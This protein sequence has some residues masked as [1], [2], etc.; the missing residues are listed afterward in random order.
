MC[1]RRS[2]VRHWSC[3]FRIDRIGSFY[4][5]MRDSDETPRFVRVEVILNSAV[6]CVTFIDA[7]Y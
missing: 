3:P 2:D 5:T 7:D 1:V 4:I 6:F